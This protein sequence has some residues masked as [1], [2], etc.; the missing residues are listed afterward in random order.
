MY[1]DKYRHTGTRGH[2]PTLMPT[3]MHIDTRTC[4]CRKHKHTCS[5]ALS[6]AYTHTHRRTHA[7]VHTTLRHKRKH[8]HSH[9]TYMCSH[10]GCTCTCTHAHTS[11]HIELCIRTL[12][13]S[14]R[15]PF[16]PSAQIHAMPPVGAAATSPLCCRRVGQPVQQ[17]CPCASPAEQDAAAVTFIHHRCGQDHRWEAIRLCPGCGRIGWLVCCA[18]RLNLARVGS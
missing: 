10:F 8:T 9:A 16:P 12:T 13:P 18:F 2:M 17:R 14:C 4:A 6:C 7:C 1:T 11:K 5:C 15:P 3:R